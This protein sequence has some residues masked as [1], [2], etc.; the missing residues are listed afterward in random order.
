MG[1]T[2][3]GTCSKY[4]LGW[5]AKKMAA[6]AAAA[7]GAERAERATRAEGAAGVAMVVDAVTATLLIPNRCSRL[8]H[9]PFIS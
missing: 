8:A 3:V 2:Y 1:N 6:T 4:L 7:E 9:P 5:S